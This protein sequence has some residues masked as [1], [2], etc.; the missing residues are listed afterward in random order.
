MLWLLRTSNGVLHIRRQNSGYGHVQENQLDCGKSTLPSYG[1]LYC[2]ICMPLELSHIIGT[3]KRAK[4]IVLFALKWQFA[5]VY[6]ND[7]VIF[8]SSATKRIAHMRKVIMTQQG[9]CEA[10]AQEEWFHYGKNW[11]FLRHHSPKAIETRSHTTVTICRLGAPAN[12]R[13]VCLFF[14]LYDVFRSFV[15]SF[16]R[17][18]ASLSKELR[19]DQPLMFELLYEEDLLSMQLVKNTL[20]SPPLLAHPNST[21]LLAFY[22]DACDVQV[23]SVLK[24]EKHE[25]TMKLIKYW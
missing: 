19:K 2:F 14:G 17:L 16:A 15:P 8:S 18:A 5:L 23:G 4:A 7:V 11:L 25:K 24:Q 21:G 22:A 10:K 9:R 12:L 3:C 1:G 6:L 20:N 13:E